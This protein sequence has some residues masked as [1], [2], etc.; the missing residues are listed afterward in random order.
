M[1]NGKMVQMLIRTDVVKYLEFKAVDGSFVVRDKKVHKVPATD[2]EALSSPLMGFFQKRKARSFFIFVQDYVVDNPQTWQGLDL[3]RM[4]M[5]AVFDHFG[6]DEGTTDFIGHSL[7]LHQS[8][9]YMAAQ[10]LPTVLTSGDL[11]FNQ[12]GWTA[13]TGP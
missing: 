10:A 11:T 2:M 13:C 12:G 5:R 6:L 4:P 8:D 7:A 9:D 3:R 1:A